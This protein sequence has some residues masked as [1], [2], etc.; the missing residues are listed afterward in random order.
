MHEAKNRLNRVSDSTNTTVAT[1]RRADTMTNILNYPAEADATARDT[2]MADT[3]EVYFS[4][5]LMGYDMAEVN[6]YIGNL[7]DAYQTA[8]D[9]YNS[10][11][12]K[13]N[14][15]LE[16]YKQLS[17]REDEKKNAAIL[18]KTLMNAETLA[19]NIISDAQTEAD[20]IKTN[21]QTESSIIK[22]NAQTEAQKI[23]DEAAK[24][25]T[26]VQEEAKRIISEAQ[27][28]ANQISICAKRDMEQADEIIK[29]SICRLQDILVSN[30]YNILIA[31]KTT[32][33]ELTPD[34]AKNDET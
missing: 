12:A 26:L 33:P 11:C 28:E 20:M 25:A 23:L 22:A 24:I 32:M 5:Q 4:K 2:K 13:Y 10:V 30:P 9:E 8:Y 1:E 7:A 18:T 6:H 34:D 3:K 15:L 14:S 16:E 17:E 29:Q 27:M 19:S 21:A 31:Q